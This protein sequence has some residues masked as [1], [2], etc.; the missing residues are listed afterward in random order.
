MYDS[1]LNSTIWLI[2]SKDE[3]TSSDYF[4]RIFSYL[5]LCC[6][7]VTLHALFTFLQ[8]VGGGGGDD[9]CFLTTLLDTLHETLWPYIVTRESFESLVLISKSHQI[10]LKKRGRVKDQTPVKYVYGSLTLSCVSFVVAFI[11]FSKVSWYF[12]CNC[13]IFLS[14]I[15]GRVEGSPSSLRD[16]ESHQKLF[17]FLFS[18]KIGNV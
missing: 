1:E 5:N 7:Y 3:L 13:V 14:C 15:A 12:V 6:N 4:G 11:C 18:F 17:R 9:Y 16:L 8:G 10:H 2:N